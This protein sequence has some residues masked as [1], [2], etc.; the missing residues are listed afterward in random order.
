MLQ[1]FEKGNMIIANERNCEHGSVRGVLRGLGRC[2]L[3]LSDPFI[4]RILDQWS[5]D[6]PSDKA[7]CP[8]A[9]NN[10]PR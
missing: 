6:S 8:A 5:Y 1:A 7:M 2:T 9:T 4:L 10:K 3:K